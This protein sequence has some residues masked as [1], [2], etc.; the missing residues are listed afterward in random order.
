MKNIL[1]GKITGLLVTGIAGVLLHAHAT[2][3]S[4]EIHDSVKITTPLVKD[5]GVSLLIE[6]PEATT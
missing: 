1:V 4:F 3:T 5:H 2:E 6:L